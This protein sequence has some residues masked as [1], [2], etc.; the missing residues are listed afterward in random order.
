MVKLLISAGVALALVCKPP[1]AGDGMAARNLRL[2]Q[3]V[4]FLEPVAFAMWK[5]VSGGATAPGVDIAAE[6]NRAANTDRISAATFPTTDGRTL[7]GF[8]IAARGEARAF[9]LVALGNAMTA[10]QVV[11]HFAALHNGDIDIYLADYRGYGHSEGKTRLRALIHYFRTVFSDLKSRPEYTRAFA[12]R[13][14]MGGVIVSNALLKNGIQADG[15]AIDGTPS[16]LPRGLCPRDYDP[17]K[18][19]QETAGVTHD[20]LLTSGGTDRVV[21]RAWMGPLIRAVEARGGT[22]VLKEH[23]DHPFIEPLGTTLERFNRAMKFFSARM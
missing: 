12:L 8:R 1:A 20:I 21:S 10:E 4:Y 7:H 2:E 23:Y 15:I 14:S 13:I 19:V 5:H 6:W 18:V 3:S 22:T 16:T 9:L 11:G 17:A